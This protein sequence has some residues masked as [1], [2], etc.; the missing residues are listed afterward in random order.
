MSYDFVTSYGSGGAEW[1]F[2]G[3]S[4]YLRVRVKNY[5]TVDVHGFS[6]EVEFSDFSV[7]RF[8][9]TTDSQKTESMPLRPGESATIEANVTEDVSAD[10]EKIIVRNGMDCT[11]LVMEL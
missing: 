10:P 8:V 3:S 9:P 4:D 6:F 11:P 7:R 2:S 1:D 5:G